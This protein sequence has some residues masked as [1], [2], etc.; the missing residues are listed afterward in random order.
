MK[1][2]TS[3][4]IVSTL[5]RASINQE[6]LNLCATVSQANFRLNGSHLS[7]S[8]M[9]K[10]TR[11]LQKYTSSVKAEVYLDL[12]GNKLRIGKLKNHLQLIPEKMVKL[13]PGS[14]SSIGHIPIPHPEI[15]QQ[16]VTGDILHLQDAEIKLEIAEINSKSILVRI[17]EGG[18]LRSKAGINFPERQISLIP[19]ST[20]P[21][22]QLKLSQ[23]LGIQNLALSYVK[24]ELDIQ[25]LK[26]LCRNLGYSPKITAKIEHPESLKNLEKICK[27]ADEI[28]FCRGDLGS[29]IPWKELG[30]W[31]GYSIEMAKNS[32]K[33]IMIAGQVFQHLTEHSQPTRSEVVH[34]YTLQKLGVDGI[35]LSDETAIGKNPAAALKEIIKLF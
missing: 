23:I 19:Q 3:F 12:Q 21:G 13:K 18:W 10:Y 14:Y 22:K 35:V 25:E 32:G 26:N 31:Q 15:F 6:F 2:S 4:K 8:E 20:I 9:Q 34:F 1:T 17:L 30:Y 33:P 28:W 27:T 7:I 16:A 24:S 29:L 11:I 5:G